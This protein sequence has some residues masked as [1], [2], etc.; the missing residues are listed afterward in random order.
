MNSAQHNIGTIIKEKFSS[1]SRC[2]SGKD[3]L[4]LSVKTVHSQSH[5]TQGA[6]EIRIFIGLR[7]IL[8][9]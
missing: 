4:A 6:R 7:Q 3:F 2:C 1:H 5:D 8:G 9:N